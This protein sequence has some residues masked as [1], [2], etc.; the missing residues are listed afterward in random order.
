MGLNVKRS[1]I[2]SLE[3]R[4]E[5]DKKGIG[6][7]LQGKR[8]N[9]LLKEIKKSKSSSAE[10]EN[11]E[12]KNAEKIFLEEM[13][14]FHKKC[15][16]E[17]SW[18]AVS[19]IKPP[20]D[21]SQDGPNKSKAVEMYENYEPGFFEKIF[22]FMEERKKEKLLK[23]IEEAEKKD[24]AL[25]LNYEILHELSENIIN[26]NIDA[27]FQVID[28]MRPFDRLLKC[29]SEI[30]IG[31]NDP[32]SIEVEFKA[33]SE[34]VISK[35]RF[36]KEIIKGDSEVEITYYEIVEEY[37]CSSILL[38]AKNIMNIIPV[39]KVV[40]HAVDNVLDIDKGMKDNITILSIVFDRDTLKRLNI[41][42]ISPVDAIDYFIC[43]MR[44][45]KTSG[46]RSV[47]RIAQ[48]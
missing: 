43:N 48:Y 7:N 33:N 9:W 29:G 5:L 2:I 26:G 42:S 37:V 23:N 3:S 14:N 20:Y 46:F 28:E 21:M 39:N 40:I 27:Y 6:V 44:H 31:T 41:N 11:I 10:S 47:E 17:I 30:E 45:Q 34:D 4:M 38:I 18:K 32:Y 12:N 19:S 1:A 15:C 13:R 16:S 36:E 35:S 8:L 22:K 24:K 25:C